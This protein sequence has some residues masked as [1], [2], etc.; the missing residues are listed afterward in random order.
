MFSTFFTVLLL[1][2]AICWEFLMLKLFGL[3]LNTFYMIV[4]TKISLTL[5]EIMYFQKYSAAK[6]FP[7]GYKIG[8]C[9]CLQNL[10]IF[11]FLRLT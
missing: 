7:I 3:V 10:L 2:A 5:I 6:K 4:K 11:L 1:F 8:K 9:F